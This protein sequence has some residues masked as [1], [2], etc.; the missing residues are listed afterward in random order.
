MARIENKNVRR[1]VEVYID[2][3]KVTQNIRA[4]EAEARKLTKQIK[5]MTMGTEEYIATSKRLQQLNALIAEHRKEIRGVT[6]EH[7]SLLERVNAWIGKW[8]ASLALVTAGLTGIMMAYNKMR[9][10]MREREDTKA[11]VKAL[12]GLD[13]DAID[14]LEQQAVELST[15]VTEAGVRIRQDATEI[16]D[17]FKLVG[18]AKPDLL[19]NK[20]AL[21]DVTEQ[22]LILAQASGLTLK[23]AVDAVTLSMNQYGAASSEAARYANVMAA[24]SKYG[25]AAVSSVTTA[26]TKAGVAASTAGVP[27]E[28][29]VGSIEALAEKGIK[30]EVAGTGLKTFFLKLEKQASDVRPSVVGLQTALE[31]LQKKNLSAEQMIKMFGLSTYTVAEAM[32]SSAQKVK[33]YSDVVEGTATA[34]EQAAIKSD[35]AQAKLEQLKNKLG[36]LGQQIAKDL[37]PIFSKIVGLGTKMVQAVPVIINFFKKYG[38][39]IITVVGALTLYK[40]ATLAANMATIT[41]YQMLRK[42]VAVKL[43]LK[44]AYTAL[45]NPIALFTAAIAGV[46]YAILKVTRS[47]DMAA[48]KMEEWGKIQQKANDNTKSETEN[49]KQ[50]SDIVHDSSLAYNVRKKALEDLQ[51]I[52]P[53][54]HASL[55]KEGKLINDN[56]EAVDR[57]VKSIVLQAQA[58][59]AATKL[60]EAQ[61]KFLELTPEQRTAVENADKARRMAANGR[62]GGD[63]EKAA[64]EEFGYTSLVYRK[65]IE[66]YDKINNEVQMYQEMIDK[67][68]K[69]IKANYVATAAA[70]TP[71]GG[72]GGG[73]NGS[74]TS[75]TARQKALRAAIAAVDA[76]YNKKEAELKR[77]YIEGEVKTEEEY[78]ERLRQLQLGRLKAKM[79]I[80]GLDEKTQSEFLDKIM[81][82]EMSVRKRIEDLVKVSSKDTVEAQLAALDDAE[83]SSKAFLQDAYENGIIPTEEKYDEYLLALERNFAIK[84][85][86]LKEKQA[87][88]TL[89][90]IEEEQNKE[91]AELKSRWLNRLMTEEA[92]EKAL[93]DIKKKYAA[94]KAEV[95]NLSAESTKKVSKETTQVEEE[96]LEAENKALKKHEEKIKEVVEEISE[97]IGDLGESI[98][99]A[100]FSEDQAKAWKDVGKEFLKDALA[101]VEKFILIKQAQILA[102]KIAS[103]SA[104]GPAGVTKAIVS[105]GLKMAAIKAAFGIAKGAISNF[106]EGGFTPSGAWNDPKGIVHSN[107]F[108]ANRFATA[109]TQVL[110][111]LKLI[112]ASQKTGSI[113]NLRGS[114]IAAVANAADSRNSAAANNIVDLSQIMATLQRLDKTMAMATDAYRQPSRAICYTEGKGGIR[115]ALELGDK[116]KNNASR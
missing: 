41:H 88:E 91:M 31:N 33:Y 58:S 29:L 44:A 80:N 102:E 27:I 104:L 95:E 89:K 43:A 79:Q 32:I 111:V 15:T 1:G 12:T 71:E 101:I 2:G 99:E 59:V 52:V 42:M 87:D 37:A 34:T 93:L 113:A 40:V 57:Y 20:E 84:R 39:E 65:L 100:L 51:S 46:G 78:S 28:Q 82:I 66:E 9:A 30:D 76:E 25:A 3:K 6:E 47:V 77:Q 54:Y 108:V 23:D 24:G 74:T 63:A 17:A 67:V 21:R 16:L 81:D 109:N 14:W 92:Y 50:L 35:T 7:K 10:A 106:W 19:Q 112:D 5:G 26:V 83:T 53:D 98:G 73:G 70:T 48:K 68:Q 94:K 86:E 11:D 13:D 116:L 115:E 61:S 22:A 45:L 18:S 8:G 85:Q 69:D 75:E 55:T 36:E 60:I 96:G 103:S 97:A 62:Y 49:I 105:A 114:Q 38:V 110:P 90:A 56:I 107:E 72:G 64:K 4:I